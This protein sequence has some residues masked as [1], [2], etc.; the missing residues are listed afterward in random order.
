M[1]EI[2]EKQREFFFTGTTKDIK[3]RRD[4]LKKLKPIIKANESVL[5]RAIDKD[6]KK[7]VFETYGTELGIIYH[8]IDLAVNNLN[9][10][11]KPKQVQTNLLNFP[12]RSYTIPEPL[13]VSLVIGAWNFP[14]QLSLVPAISSI[15][16]G[17]TVVLKPSEVPSSTSSVMAG[18]INNNFDPA[19]FKVV[20]GGILETT[21]LLGQRFD[22]I[23]FTGSTKVGRIV[24][25]AAAKHLTPV[26]LELGGKSPAF[27]TQSCNLKIAVKRLV[28]GKFLNAGQ[29]CLA[30][31]YILVHSSKKDELLELLKK[32]IVAS[33]YSYENDNYVQIINQSNMN[34]LMAALDRSKIYCGGEIN[35]DE[36]FISPT[37]MHNVSFDDEIMK[38]EIFGPIL[39]VIEYNSLD[40]AINRVKSLPRPLACY[41]FTNKKQIKDKVLNSISFGGGAVNDAVMHFT[42]SNLPF[43]GVGASGIGSYHGKFGFDAFSHFKSVLDKP[44]WLE[45]NLKYT[46]RKKWKLKVITWLLGQRQTKENRLTL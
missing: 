35:L 2:V 6:F 45:L 39:P 11:A 10:W 24:Y 30:V 38:D 32:E 17:N 42:N 31:D 26:S 15:A 43:G 44:T 9:S 12:A 34:R 22:K 36:R 41:V 1:R 23:F 29:S 33:K 21:A 27:I 46:P 4:Q 16:A 37:V 25:K 20:E 40:E 18:L 19:F 14:Y 8:E 7:S 5:Y 13:G 3:F 28:W